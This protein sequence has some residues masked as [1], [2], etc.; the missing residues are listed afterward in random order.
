MLQ[1]QTATYGVIELTN[2][3]TRDYEGR[4]LPGATVLASSTHSPAILFQELRFA[5]CTFQYI[6]SY[7]PEKTNLIV[8]GDNRSLQAS[9]SLQNRIH[10]VRAG[11]KIRLREGQVALIPGTGTNC[12]FLLSA[13][14]EQ[15]HFSIAYDTSM[16]QP[17]LAYFPKLESAIEGKVNMNSPL[18]VPHYMPR[19]VHEIINNIFTCPYEPRLRDFYF[20]DQASDL[21]MYLLVEATHQKPVAKQLSPSDIEKIHIARNLILHDVTQHLTISKLA[22]RV[23]L[24][25]FKIKVGF[26]QLFGTGPFT[27]LRDARMQKAHD[28]LQ[29]TDKTLRDIAAQ[30]GFSS[31]SSF[32]GAFQKHFGYKT[33]D[34][35]HR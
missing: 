5:K 28:L 30:A 15:V 32:V 12:E 22:R 24:N 17:L 27:V 11:T 34:V 18:S 16:I 6:K 9:A 25:E 35:K 2:L 3:D 10:Q 8:P 29:H 7:F 31:L 33:G 19:Q 21:L 1:V 20:E 4:L 13:G 26:K 23:E 14:K